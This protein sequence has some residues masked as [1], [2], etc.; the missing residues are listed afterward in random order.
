MIIFKTLI[1]LQLCYLDSYLTS[2]HPPTQLI[3]SPARCKKSTFIL[4]FAVVMIKNPVGSRL[5]LATVFQ[6]TDSFEIQSLKGGLTIQPIDII[7]AIDIWL[8]PG[9]I[10][11]VWCWKNFKWSTALRWIRFALG[12]KLLANEKIAISS[13]VS[14]ATYGLRA[15]R[16][17]VK[18]IYAKW[19]RRAPG[20]QG[21]FRARRLR[22]VFW[23][24]L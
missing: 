13:L 17:V 16:S 14:T 6:R 8:S 1:T 19:E 21:F 22:R 24:K 5:C 10:K 23:G 15:R 20:H 3:P 9:K 2:E 4:T 7:G 11:N 18:V 12:P